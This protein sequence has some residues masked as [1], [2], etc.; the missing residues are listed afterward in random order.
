MK[1]LNHMRV[2]K[3]TISIPADLF[4]WGEEERAR[5]HMSR[6]EFIANLYRRYH[7]E[8]EME[9]RIA[10]YKAAYAK[11][12]ETDEERALTEMSMQLLAAEPDTDDADRPAE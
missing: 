12:P 8:L 7:D 11:L 5:T 6:S 9:R 1:T 10:R 2:E 4:A 3:V